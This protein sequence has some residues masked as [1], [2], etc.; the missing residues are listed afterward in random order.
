MDH[1]DLSLEAESPNPD[2]DPGWYECIELLDRLPALEIGE[3]VQAIERLVRNASPGIRGRALRMGAAVLS[4]D[5]LTAYLRSDE[6]DI[7]RNAGLEMLKMR[8]SRGFT[9]ALQLLKDPDPDVALQAVLV[10]D[11]LKDP[12]ALEPL[13]GQLGH[14]EINVLQAIIVAIGHLGDARSIPDLLPFLQA[15]AWLQAA[16][17]EAMGDI[18]S[19]EGVPALSKLLTDLMI[20][21][22]AAEALARIGG[23]RAFRSMVDH[24]LRFREEL[25]QEFSLG[26]LAHMLEGLRRPPADPGG[27]RE[28]LT[29]FLATGSGA[30]KGS[31]A[32]CLLCLGP[33]L[34]DDEAL[35]ILAYRLREPRLLP[36]CLARRSDLAGSLLAAEDHRRAWGILLCGRHPRKVPVA[37]LVAALWRPLDPEW[38][39]FVA[40]TLVKLRRPEISEAILDLFCQL[41]AAAR[42][43]LGPVLQAHRKNLRPLLDTKANLSP[44]IRLVLRAWLGDSGKKIAE[45]ITELSRDSRVEVLSYVA[46]LPD[47]VR[48]LPW[49]RWLETD[50]ERFCPLAVEAAVEAGMRDLVPVLRDLLSDA[51]SP[52]LIRAMGE[53]GD[54]ESVGPMVRLLDPPGA[55]AAIVLES[56]GRIG[57]PEVRST[58]RR[59]AE[60]DD[61]HLARIAFKGLSL[62]ATEEDDEFFRGQAAH[63]D[64][65]VRLACAEVLGRF[66]RPDNL[67]A[68]AQLA[69]DPVAIVA[70]RALSLLEPEGSS[71]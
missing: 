26:L 29:G 14:S 23:V 18:R 49:R 25:D 4:D 68:L 33:S 12:R 59:V 70:Q 61:E 16:A 64:W 6:D 32:R 15:D 39:G 11:H 27:L 67:A 3:R 20:G 10:L 53:L 63:G 56:L 69:A 36:A 57:G 35:E 9:L 50:P 58:L 55:Y 24:T 17:V 42:P 21:P 1:L 71:K 8:G 44:E 19:T 30:E 47:I 22:L 2:S 5:T 65:Y 31:A 52:E 45:S 62:C 48:S 38:L 7:L 41:P 13:R 51:P 66:Q 54:R 37:D 43:V 34:T 40:D 46:D 28:F 60:G